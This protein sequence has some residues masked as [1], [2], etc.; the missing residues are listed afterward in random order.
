MVKTLKDMVLFAELPTARIEELNRQVS[1]RHVDA[2]H[3]IIDHMD[4]STDLYAVI[5]GEVR[6]AS[7]AASGKVVNYRDIGAGEM[8]GEFSAI[9][10]LP[11]SATVTATKPSLI[12]SMP[13]QIF[14]DLIR[15]EPDIAAAMLKQL[16]AQIRNL[17]QR[18]FEISIL[19]VNNRIRSELLRM[20]QDCQIE[21]DRVLIS[22]FPTHAEFASRIATHREAVTKE[23][24]K[25]ARLGIVERR[26][27][28]LM[29]CRLGALTELVE[30]ALHD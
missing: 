25:L 26:T 20:A 29:V 17:T 16:A 1:W 27:D 23:L 21:E 8:F 15:E 3:Q 2:G 19:A 10:G 24:N 7:F 13:A 11:R 22:D 30:T 18:I 14:W 9:D 4:T 5:E 6:A 12:A 28:G